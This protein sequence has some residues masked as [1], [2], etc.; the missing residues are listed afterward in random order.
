MSAEPKPVIPRM[1][2]A[3]IRINSTSTMS[4]TAAPYLLRTDLKLSCNYGRYVFVYYRDSYT[5]AGHK[6]VN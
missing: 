2:Y 1:K 4:A 6:G 5:V 3:L